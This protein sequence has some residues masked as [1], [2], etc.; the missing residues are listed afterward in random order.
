MWAN[1][2]KSSLI[3][4][5]DPGTGEVLTVLNAASL[6]PPEVAENAS[7]VLNGIAYDPADDTFL[8][9]GKLWPAIYRVRIQVAE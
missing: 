2:W 1:I 5:I 3:I 6:T 8:L 9:T 7:A 4:E